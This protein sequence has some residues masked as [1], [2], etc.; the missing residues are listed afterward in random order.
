MTSPMAAALAVPPPPPPPPPP[1]G[2]K[3]KRHHSHQV[4]SAKS[5]DPPSTRSSTSKHRTPMFHEESDDDAHEPPSLS[6]ETKRTAVEPSPQN[7]NL[8]AEFPVDALQ[9]DEMQMLDSLMNHQSNAPTP[10]NNHH[11]VKPSIPR[12]PEQMEPA[13]TPRTAEESPTSSFANTASLST[14]SP[15]ER[16]RQQ[17]RAQQQ[18]QQQANHNSHQSVATFKSQDPPAT[19]EFSTR[20]PL[21]PTPKL[22]HP[23]TTSS[24]H[25]T[26]TP[27]LANQA[28]PAS[29]AHYNSIVNASKLTVHGTPAIPQ[30]PIKKEQSSSSSSSAFIAPSPTNSSLATEPHS[31]AHAV[32]VVKPKTTVKKQPMVPPTNKTTTTKPRRRSPTPPESQEED[33]NNKKKKGFF[34]RMF[35][36]KDSKKGKKMASKSS[37]GEEDDEGYEEADETTTVGQTTI[38][39]SS[40]ATRK[41]QQQQQVVDQTAAPTTPFVDEHGFATANPG[42]PQFLNDDVST[43]TNPTLHSER[44]AQRDPTESGFAGTKGDHN[45]P[46]GHYFNFDLKEQQ[47]QQQMIVDEDD[48]LAEG[49]RASIDPFTDPFFS[50][51][52]KGAEPTPMGMAPPQNSMASTPVIRGGSNT[53]S[54]QQQQTASAQKKRMNLSVKTTIG[55]T[56]SMNNNTMDHHEDPFGDDQTQHKLPAKSPYQDPSPRGY[57]ANTTPSGFPDPMGESPLHK[58]Q[59]GPAG[60]V[61]GMAE[62]APDPPL[63]IHSHED[64]MSSSDGDGDDE[65]LGRS[66]EKKM[67]DDEFGMGRSTANDPFLM[68]SFGGHMGAV[69]PNS[70]Q[71]SPGSIGA[72]PAAPSPTMTA[73]QHKT[74]RLPPSPRTT[75]VTRGEKKNGSSAYDS[76]KIREEHQSAPEMPQPTTRARPRPEDVI[77]RKQAPKVANKPEDSP[78]RYK[79]HAERYPKRKSPRRAPTPVSTK[80]EKDQT[81]PTPSPTK[82]MDKLMIASM[83]RM[84]A[85]AVAYMHTLNGEPSP[86]NAWKKTNI[87]EETPRNKPAATSTTAAVAKTQYKS[88]ASKTVKSI[89]PVAVVSPSNY[90]EEKHFFR[91]YSGK[92]RG[93]RLTGNLPTPRARVPKSKVQFDGS[94][95]VQEKEP[96][97]PR[98][99][100]AMPMDRDIAVKAD[101]VSMGFA[102]FRYR[103]EMDIMSGKS[104]RVVPQ[105]APK[106]KSQHSSVVEDDEPMDPIARAGRRLLSKAA[107]PIQAGVRRF[108]AQQE[109]VDRMWALIEIQSYMRRWRAEANLLACSLAAVTIQRM[110]R[111]CLARRQLQTSVQA[112]TDIQRIVRGHL[113]QAWAF[114][115]V[116]SV[117]ILQALARR[118]LARKH[119]DDMKY[120]AATRVQTFWRTHSTRLEYRYTM[121]DIIIVQ[122]VVRSFMARRE[123][124]NRR[125]KLENDSSTMI[126]KNWRAHNGVIHYKNYRAARKI[127]SAWRGF[128]GYTDYIFY[129]VDILLVQRVCRRWLAIQKTQRIRNS[130]AAT[131]IQTQ[132][133]VFAARMRLYKDLAD[134]IRVQSIARRFLAGSTVDMRKIEHYEETAAATKIQAAWKGFWSF[135]HFVIMQFEITK[136]QALFRGVLTRQKQQFRL[137]CCILIQAAA[138]RYVAKRYVDNYRIERAIILSKAAELRERLAAEK[139]QFWWVVVQECQKEK[140]A[141]LVIERFFIMVKE[142]VEKEIMR[143]EKRKKK[144]RG[145]KKKGKDVM[146]RVNLNPGDD[147]QIDIGLSSSQSLATPMSV[148]TSTWTPRGPSGMTPKIP[149]SSKSGIS[150]QMKTPGQGTP[151][152]HR[153]PSPSV[154][155]GMRQGEVIRHKD[156]LIS[157]TRNTPTRV[158]SNSPA[159]SRYSKGVDSLAFSRSEYSDETSKGSSKQQ[160]KRGF[161]GPFNSQNTPQS[162]SDN[163]NKYMNMYGLK[164]GSGRSSINNSK[165]SH[166]FADQEEDDE[167]MTPMARQPAPTS[168]GRMNSA[169][170]SPVPRPTPTY[171]AADSRASSSGSDLK[172]LKIATGGGDSSDYQKALLAAAK[173]S[174]GKGKSKAANHQMTPSPRPYNYQRGQLPPSSPSHQSNVSAS[175]ESSFLAGEEFGMI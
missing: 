133:R 21:P 37:S 175:D 164:S 150:M 39:S 24:S 82:K 79:T 66:D 91:A 35:K 68:G 15:A 131:K 111:G 26:A 78:T 63:F 97:T 20:S 153:S 25:T 121:T 109:A 2:S 125:F 115:T 119:V 1:A 100:A 47:Q 62:L 88:S 53:T 96:M 142:E 3:K 94:Q 73:R 169:R 12:E 40:L 106:K 95:T 151:V 138:R 56:P 127:Q 92:F 107:V 17:H 5:T 54:K 145:K 147:G 101:V 28:T 98:T 6:K 81:E 152:R 172:G 134:V 156:V 18:Q 104:E 16:R 44:R 144:R 30:Q 75:R 84:N 170:S 58:H 157:D 33:A 168:A 113:A 143:Q 19:E 149:S 43:L 148:A 52:N 67:N 13:L 51:D 132:W 74:P 161:A 50:D 23:Q 14:A 158:R 162:K 76:S 90:V 48:I 110:M 116:F 139:I 77:P 10:N 55:T 103:R 65:V 72:F 118:F 173:A 93:R 102:A 38:A 174:I 105:P 128:Q 108:L 155:R 171:S 129:L 45:E 114:D 64:D 146:S 7:K 140:A 124:F 120:A 61:D 117:I 36:R 69:P 160:S 154:D 59:R 89:P 130:N 46:V 141:A 4:P 8:S 85:K 29:Q 70:S 49:R 136:I 60:V 126:Q 165:S 122:S 99:L 135:S 80:S 137:G 86:R 163:V 87:E 83:A 42:S 27:A 123:A 71:L 11:P 41:Q 166:F 57:P 31:N 112:A 9:M 159:N 34:G 32:P 167:I 22:V